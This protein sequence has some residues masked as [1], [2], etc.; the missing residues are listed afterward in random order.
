MVV[1]LGLLAVLEFALRLALGPPPPPV[2]VYSALG[3]HER[4]LVA[5]DGRIS[6]PYI[7]IDPPSSAEAATGP[8]CAVLGGS[9]VHGGSP[10]HHSQEFPALLGKALGIDVVNLA[11]PGL[12]SF[13]M[14]R[15]VDD[16]VQWKWAC[17][18]LYGPHNDFGNAVFQERF[19][20][21]LGALGA[22]GNAFL[23][24]FQLYAQLGRA[25]NASG[26]ARSKQWVSSMEGGLYGARRATALDYLVANHR[27]MVWTARRAGIATVVVSPVADITAVPGVD[28]ATGE[29]AGSVYREAVRLAD[30]DPYRAASLLR[31][32]R[33][34]DPVALRA[35]TEAGDRLR[36][37]CEEEGAVYA[38]VERLLP[39]DSALPVPSGDLFVDPVHFS[40]AGHR[41]MAVALEPFV[42]RAAFGAAR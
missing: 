1:A 29:C 42:A 35:P 10:V 40:A 11:S 7:E 33:D 3:E 26:R 37:M 12:D 19:G 18:V 39:E 2:R 20:S 38:D 24:R 17:V 4:Y 21:P 31:R 14:L 25:M 15:V 32:A 5:Q 27:R 36:A 8:R 9:S 6:T 22:H 30:I 28:C 23:G 34:I 13:D 41:A 16:M